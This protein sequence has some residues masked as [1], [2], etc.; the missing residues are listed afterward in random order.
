VVVVVGVDNVTLGTLTPESLAPGSTWV[1]NRPMQVI[2]NLAVGGPWARVHRATRRGSPPR[3][4]STR[5]DGTRSPR[6]D[7]CGGPI[8]NCDHC[9]IVGGA[10]R[11]RTVIGEANRAGRSLFS[12]LART[13]TRPTAARYDREKSW[14]EPNTFSAKAQSAQASCCNPP[15]RRLYVR[16]SRKI[17]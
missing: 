9:R 2:L 13:T 6:F 11:R 16:V 12:S 7:R 8:P 1:Y 14:V 5:S 15:F 17:S 3:C 4:M 10:V